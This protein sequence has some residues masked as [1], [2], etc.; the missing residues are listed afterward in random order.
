MNEEL[1]NDQAKLVDLLIAAHNLG[2]SHPVWIEFRRRTNNGEFR[3][4]FETWALDNGWDGK[5]ETR[6][7]LWWKF[8]AENPTA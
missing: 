7:K 2:H 6:L 5:E 4:D 3:R 8:L 1:T